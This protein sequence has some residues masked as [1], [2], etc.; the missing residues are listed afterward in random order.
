GR[1][2]GPAVLAMQAHAP[3]GALS[4]ELEAGADF[5]FVVH[6]ASGMV[7]A[8]LGVSVGE[9]LIRLRAYPFAHD[10]SLSEVAQRL[11][12]A[13][14]PSPDSPPGTRRGNA[15]FGAGT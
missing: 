5:H 10:R 11:W 3:A 13:G 2:G 7:S 1:R 9:A 4:A 8:Q 14:S 15:E 12:P 6:Q